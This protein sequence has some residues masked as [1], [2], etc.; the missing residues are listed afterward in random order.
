MDSSAQALEEFLELLPEPA[1]LI[2]DRARVV[3]TNALAA[4]LFGVSRSDLLT[5]PVD[6]LLTEVSAWAGAGERA[7]EAVGERS[8]AQRC[9]AP[10][11]NA[12]AGTDSAHVG[13]ENAAPG[14]DNGEARSQT[15]C[16]L[17][18][19]D[20]RRL[21][22][23]VSHRPFRMHDKLLGFVII[24]D[25][26]GRK[27]AE[28]EL[29][30]SEERL[31]QAVRVSEI[32]IFDHD[33]GTDI[34]YWSPRQREMYGWA[35]AEP[36]TIP[37]FLSRLHPDDREAIGIGIRRA[38]DPAGDGSFDVEHR[39]IRSDG[40]IRWI[41]TRSIT[42]FAGEGAER[43]PIRT[44]GASVDFTDRKHGEEGRERLAGT[45]DATP[46]FVAVADA[47]QRLLY[48][49]RAAH[50]LLGIEPGVDLSRVNV[51]ERR[52]KWAVQLL[53]ETA[54]PTA[55]QEGA[56]RGETAFLTHEGE[57]VPFSQVVL[58]HPG[59]DGKVAFLSTIAR[60]ISKEKRLEAQFLQAQK[61]EAV[62]QLAGGLAHD[63]NNLL[64]VILNATGLV[65]RDLPP[66]H[67]AQEAL[68][69]VMSASERAAEL[70]RRVLAFSRKQVL[71]LQTV[72]L[73]EVL[74]GMMPMLRRLLGDGVDPVMFLEP[75]LGQIKADRTQLEQVVLNLVVNARDA[76]QMG[77]R[78]TIETSNVRSRAVGNADALA[79]GS[80]VAMTVSDTG[81]GMAPATQ[82]RLF[83]PYFTTKSPG[84]G[85]GLGLSMVFGI[86]KQSGGDIT[87]A[88]EL[89]RGT[90][91]KVQFPRVGKGGLTKDRASLKSTSQAKSE[92]VLLVEDEVPLRKLIASF[93]EQSGYVVLAAAGPLEALAL[94]R[95][96]SEHIDLLLTDMVMPEM[97]G[98]ELAD[99]LT[100]ERPA[101]PV[102]YT[103]GY[104]DNGIV[105]GG[106]LPPDVCLLSKPF[107][108]DE[109]LGKVRKV[110][111]RRGPTREAHSR[112]GA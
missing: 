110:I 17:L 40:E 49:N 94:A 35:E 92:V 31:R 11:E 104:V 42:L 52:P 54:I 16:V 3:G 30:T 83:E 111:G 62:G 6:S 78:L 34:H 90:T 57:E 18:C 64:A 76:M 26:T 13:T 20:G 109:L 37:T 67:P 41:A 79:A 107:T 65:Q 58:A 75:D 4:E 85:T 87:V 59:S 96:H 48:L 95:E 80:W 60:D 89:G 44:V 5:A 106:V 10:T 43:H 47:S 1:I 103:T 27:R 28:S 69:D 45:L 102:L 53:T 71:R 82:A 56:W 15:E 99:Q 22:V 66:E 8:G 33:H 74:R 50:R 25:I 98:K 73:N 81:I 93:L 86:V 112:D 29:K 101:T 63:F 38:H 61:M 2:S 77:G 84:R 32:G 24:R 88:S 51:M 36:I 91:F 72:D 19:R 14:A 100:A 39:I 46:D 70:T 108:L 12:V 7:V 23:E 97:S 105:E 55:M 9:V 21:P 68:N